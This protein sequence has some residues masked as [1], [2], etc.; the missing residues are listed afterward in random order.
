MPKSSQ[1]TVDATID[2]KSNERILFLGRTRSGKSYL[3]RYLL[4]GLKRLVVCDPKMSRA[5]GK[6]RLQ[7]WDSESKKALRA[8]D[9][10]RIRILGQADV[11]PVEYWESILRELYNIGVETGQLFIYIDDVYLL[12]SGEQGTK[13]PRAVRD[14]WTMGGEQGIG[15][16]AATQVPRYIPKYLLTEAEHLFL[17]RLTLLEH[18]QYVAESTDDRLAIPIPKEDRHGFYYY[19]IFTDDPVYFQRYEREE[20]ETFEAIAEEEESPDGKERESA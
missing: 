8:G 17:F 1:E 3:A 13:F 2:I 9:P 12:S 19:S 15:A 16:A 11:D 4:R 18:R 6:W 14:I 7:P 5:I 20:G 10:I